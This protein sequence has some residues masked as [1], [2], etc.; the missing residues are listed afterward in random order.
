MSIADYLEDGFACKY[1]AHPFNSGC[2]FHWH[3]YFEIA[4]EGM[5]A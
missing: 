2:R 3:L 1:C 4:Q 5:E